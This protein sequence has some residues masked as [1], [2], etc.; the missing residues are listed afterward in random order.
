MRS[1]LCRQGT[2][3]FVR[4]S[5]AVPPRRTSAFVSWHQRARH[6]CAVRPVMLFEMQLQEE[7]AGKHG[8]ECHRAQWVFRPWAGGHALADACPGGAHKRNQRQAGDGLKQH[9]GQPWE[10]GGLTVLSIQ[11]PQLLIL[12]RLPPLALDGGIQV[13]P[14]APHALLVCNR[15]GGAG[16]VAVGNAWV[17]GLWEAGEQGWIDGV[18]YWRAEAL[19]GAA[20][21][22]PRYFR[23]AVA[24]LVDQL[25]QGNVLIG[26]PLLPA[27]KNGGG[28]GGGVGAASDG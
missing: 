24:I 12:R 18:G 25:C 9:N 15:T 26:G 20:G 21:Q 8:M 14:P 17:G 4:A 2:P 27:E 5:H 16:E 23:P 6:C 22:A 19:T 11:L 1:V 7:P 28:G 10:G 13:A 3:P